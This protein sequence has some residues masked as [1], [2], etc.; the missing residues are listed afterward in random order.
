MERSG[1]AGRHNWIIIKR[2]RMIR[3]I[4]RLILTIM[5]LA[6]IVLAAVEAIA[7][8]VQLIDPQGGLLRIDLKNPVVHAVILAAALAAGVI[9]YAGESSKNKSSD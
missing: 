1:A 5:A 9:R 7:F 3:F 8:L 4:K 6:V 2:F